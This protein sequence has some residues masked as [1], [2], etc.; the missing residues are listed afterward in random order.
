[1]PSTEQPALFGAKP[2]I[3]PD[4]F[5]YESDVLA[6]SE[7]DALLAR[8]RSLP[9]REARYKAFTARRRIVSFGL[10]YDFDTNAPT[11]AP[12]LPTWLEPLRRRAAAWAR[13]AAEDLMQCTVAEYSPGTQLGWHRDVPMFGLVLGISLAAPCRMRFRPYPHIT[14]PKRATHAV[15]LEPRSIYVLRDAVRWR[16]QHTI[17]PTPARRYS[18][19]FRSLRAG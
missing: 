7:E 3:V 10:G 19:T 18:I 5:L 4:G 9:L 14:Q 2:P 17:S 8:V 15:L 1:M 16:W 12:P 13:V 11:P 6:E